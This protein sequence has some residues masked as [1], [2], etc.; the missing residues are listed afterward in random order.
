MSFGS[1][2][3]K[4]P[5]SKQPLNISLYNTTYIKTSFFLPLHLNIL[6]LLF[7]IHFF[8]SSSLS[9]CLSVS[10]S[11]SLSLSL[12]L[13]LLLPGLVLLVVNDIVKIV[14]YVRSREKERKDRESESE[15]KDRVSL[16]RER[17]KN[18]KKIITSCYSALS[19]MR[20]HCSKM[21]NFLA[22]GIFDGVGFCG[23]KC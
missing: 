3:S 22:Y 8:Y 13:A 1:Y 21:S 18:I 4:H 6:S 16:R 7:F 9:L 15:K 14:H 17:I 10:L 2:H 11:L 12:F 20:A 23:Y 19:K 5:S